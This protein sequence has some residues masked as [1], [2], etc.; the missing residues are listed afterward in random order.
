M[1]DALVREVREEAGATLGSPAELF[2][3]YRNAHADPRDHV[4]LYISRDWRRDPAHT[5]PGGEIAAV[6]SF[7]VSA[8]PADTSRGTLARIREVHFGEPP[9]TDW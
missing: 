3:L 4:A 6:D 1:T 8:L 2:G 9:A 7:P 5:V